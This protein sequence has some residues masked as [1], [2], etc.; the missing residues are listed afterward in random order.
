MPSFGIVSEGVTDQIV[1]ENILQGYFG[2]EE[3]TV[4]YVQP[5][6]ASEPTP[7]GWG[8]V[9]KFFELG[10]HKRALQFNDYLIVQ[11]DTDVSEQKGY[12]VP[13]HVGGLELSPKDLVA[14]V[15]QKFEGIVGAEFWAAHGHRLLF[16]IAVHGIECWLLPL[17]YNDNR[18]AKITGCLESANRELSKRNKAPLSTSGHKGESKN[19]RAYQEVSRE[20]AKWKR[21]HAIYDKNPSLKLFIEHLDARNVKQGAMSNASATDMPSPHGTDGTST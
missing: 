21:L 6:P 3:P 1:V 4:N 16:A 2:A 7:G 8:L 19:P 11:I 17:L 12:D 13:H 20:Y 14:R 10:E 15:I 5:L 18:N 9:F